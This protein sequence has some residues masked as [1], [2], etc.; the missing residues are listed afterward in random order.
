MSLNQLFQDMG[1]QL[2]E[3]LWQ[4]VSKRTVREELERLESQV[5]QSSAVLA[6]QYAAIEELRRRLAARDHRAAWLASR[7]ELY[8]HVRDQANAW[9]F[10]LKLDRLRKAIDKDRTQIQKYRLTYRSHLAHFQQL[11]HRLAVVSGQW[12][13]VSG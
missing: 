6:R 4:D 13:V 11:Q 5:H 7:V 2:Q 3:L 1:S 9:R 10:A 8:L 12:S